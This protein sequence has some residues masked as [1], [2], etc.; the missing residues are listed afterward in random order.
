MKSALLDTNVLILLIIGNASEAYISRHR[1]TK[2]FQRPHYRQLVEILS[3]YQ[4]LEV[5][6]HVLAEANSLVRQNID[7]G[8]LTDIMVALQ[9]FLSASHEASIASL[10]A[11]TSEVYERLGLTDAV[12]YELGTTEDR[13]LI[14]MDGDLFR[15]AA[16]KSQKAINLRYALGLS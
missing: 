14:T 12:L 5:P 3:Q 8:M 2:E 7:D 1:R 16:A 15:A 9:R 6:A 4:R 13:T 11:A 10:A